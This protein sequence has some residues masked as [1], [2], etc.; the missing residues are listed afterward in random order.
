M[1][2]IWTPSKQER[3]VITSETRIRMRLLQ[4]FFGKWHN[5]KN[6]PYSLMFLQLSL[7][8]RGNDYITAEE[9]AEKKTSADPSN[10]IR[11][12]HHRSECLCHNLKQIA[13]YKT[14]NREKRKGLR[15]DNIRPTEC[16]TPKTLQQNH[17]VTIHNM[18]R[19][20]DNSI[21]RS[22]SDDL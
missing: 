12:F 7:L 13:K 1:V 22:S 5:L 4:Q 9:K 3:Q 18:L 21:A 17:H 6:D 16:V 20:N 10:F 8:N 2:L 15:N 19:F 14:T 11:S